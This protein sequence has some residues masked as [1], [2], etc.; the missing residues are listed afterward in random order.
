MC[1]DN[2]SSGSMYKD[3]EWTERLIFGTLRFFS[4]FFLRFFAGLPYAYGSLPL[5]LPTAYESLPCGLNMKPPVN[6]SP[7]QIVFWVNATWKDTSAMKE[8]PH[9]LSITICGACCLPTV[10]LHSL[11][12]QLPSADAP[13]YCFG[14]FQWRKIVFFFKN[15]S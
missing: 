10:R 8:K 5:A 3:R 13:L 7:L 6:F 4:K 1:K 14:L 15:G 12:T 11:P 2:A 9:E